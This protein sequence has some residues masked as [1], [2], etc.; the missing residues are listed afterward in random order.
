MARPHIEF[1]HAQVLAWEAGPLADVEIKVLSR[2]TNSGAASLLQRYPAGWSSAAPYHLEAAEDFV[3]LEGEFAINAVPYTELTFAHLPPRHGRRGVRSVGGAVVLSFFDASPEVTQGEG[4]PAPGLIE[5]IDV[6]R[7][8]W[9]GDY[10]G[11]DSPE[12]AAA[13]AR[14]KILRSDPAA[15]DQTW[16]IGTLPLWRER[17][18]ET[19]PV[20]QEMFLLSGSIAG[21]TGIMHPGAYFWRP[22][23]I[24]H[25][26]YGSKTGNIIL[27][28]SQGGALATDYYDADPPFRFDAPHR[29]VLPPELEPLGRTP[30]TGGGRY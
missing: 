14:K 25:G 4:A 2:D 21:N 22:P 12:L 3:V 30:W 1:I 8:G 16:L 18:T 24:K 6:L 7:D 11:I 29:P 19:H 13:G 15:G 26:P 20:V 17:K 10:S 27:M 9:D 5:K 23:D 28:R